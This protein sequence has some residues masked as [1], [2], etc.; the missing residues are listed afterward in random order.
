MT[1]RPLA[2]VRRSLVAVAAAGLLLGLLVAA[3]PALGAEGTPWWRLESNSVPTYLRPGDSEDIVVVTASNLGD[4]TVD[5]STRKVKITDTLPAGL[6][7]T[8][9]VGYVGIKTPS[10]RS[11]Q[12]TC[13]LETLSCEYGE[14]LVPYERLEVLITV[15]VEASPGTV[16]NTAKVEG[17]E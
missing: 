11:G 8:A 17:G 9:I 3:A 16:T 1:G 5:G 14:D 10:G 13:K 7:P 2:L 15:K 6:T 4:A 12:M